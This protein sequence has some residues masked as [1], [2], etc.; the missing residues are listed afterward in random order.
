MGLRHTLWVHSEAW[1][2]FY[3]AALHHGYQGFEFGDWVSCCLWWTVWL[4]SPALLGKDEATPGLQ[5]R[6]MQAGGPG[7]GLLG[8]SRWKERH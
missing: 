3:P 8:P 2:S 1:S 5:P 6:T 7:P 4:W